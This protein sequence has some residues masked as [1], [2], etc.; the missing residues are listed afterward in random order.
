[1]YFMISQNIVRP[2]YDLSFQHIT[3]PFVLA[4]IPRCSTASSPTTYQL[5]H[6]A[7]S[8]ASFPKRWR[9]VTTYLVLDS[10]VKVKEV[11]LT[12]WMIKDALPVGEIDNTDLQFLFSRGELGVIGTVNVAIDAD[13]VRRIH[14]VFKMQSPA[15][16]WI[17]GRRQ[18]RVDWVVCWCPTKEKNSLW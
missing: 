6:P 2:E 8:A 9:S 15:R 11:L 7:F 12:A 18:P 3:L 17:S 4:F 10:S 1:M 13:I 16:K 14:S 5:L